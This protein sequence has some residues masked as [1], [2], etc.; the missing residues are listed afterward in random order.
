[1][2]EDHLARGTE[3]SAAAVAAGLGRSRFDAAVVMGS[4]WA[5]TADLL[6]VSERYL[7]TL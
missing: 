3:V 2:L 5:D 1:M 7:S 6:G 4:G